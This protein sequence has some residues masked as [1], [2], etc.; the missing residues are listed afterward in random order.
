M[1]ENSA[2]GKT[3]IEAEI[4][5]YIVMPVI[6]RLLYRCGCVVMLGQGQALSYK[7]GELTIQKL[8]KKYATVGSMPL[9]T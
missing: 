3:D 9:C 7:V 2:L 8:K 5:R 1:T 6:K 4:D